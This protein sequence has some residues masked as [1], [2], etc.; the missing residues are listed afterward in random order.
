MTQ[1]QSIRLLASIFIVT[2]LLSCG[3]HKA[4]L[5]AEVKELSKQVM[6]THDSVMPKMDDIFFLSK[7]LIALKSDSLLDSVR[8]N[9]MI[10]HIADLDSAGEGMLRWMR[11]YNPPAANEISDTTIA[12]L[13]KKHNE[14]KA[15][16]NE[17]LESISAAE[18]WLSQNEK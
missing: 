7:Q 9:Q 1:Q 8:K 15:V 16:R 11:T 13:L 12:Y 10:T 4:E 2:S 17:M 6:A 14:I 18:K 3:N 5:E